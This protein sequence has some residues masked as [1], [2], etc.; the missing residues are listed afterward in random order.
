MSLAATSYHYINLS[1]ESLFDW[2]PTFA[3]F[4]YL[5][6]W[7]WVPQIRHH[8]WLT[9]R[10]QLACL[11]WSTHFF[12]SYLRRFS[13][14]PFLG[15]YLHTQRYLGALLGYLPGVPTYSTSLRYRSILAWIPRFLLSLY[16]LAKLIRVPYSFRISTCHLLTEL[17]LIA[18]LP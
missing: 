8:L 6:K 1:W 17:D 5:M 14:L 2:L 11:N 7:S 12:Y 4:S 16:M 9:R 13:L 15:S 3:P 10:T 18:Y